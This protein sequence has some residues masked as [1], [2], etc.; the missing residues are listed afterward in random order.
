[1]DISKRA[2]EIVNIFK[3]LNDLNLG[4]SCFQEFND[5]REICNT[6]IRDG[7]PIDGKIK[8]LGTKRIICFKFDEKNVDCYLKYDESV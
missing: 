4:I 5:F 2:S 7:R 6:F 1:M 3:K 8:V